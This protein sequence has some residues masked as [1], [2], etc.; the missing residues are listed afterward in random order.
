M[1]GL[2]RSRASSRT[3]RYAEVVR[4]ALMSIRSACVGRASVAA[5]SIRRVAHSTT[6]VPAPSTTRRTAEAERRGRRSSSP[7]RR[8]SA[9]KPDA[10]GH[11]RPAG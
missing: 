5:V 6:A 2:R 4:D 8:G 1:P 11:P 10:A 9:G 3:R 7:G